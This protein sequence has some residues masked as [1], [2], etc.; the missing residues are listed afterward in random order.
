[1]TALMRAQ[2]TQLR[3]LRSTYVVAIAVVL[4]A[5]GIT[6][7]DLADA[8]GAK[9]DSP[10]ELRDALILDVGIVSALFAAM[11]ATLGTASEYRHQTIG[12]R[13]LGAP[14]RLSMLVARLF[15][16]GGLSAVAG[17]A[18]LGVSYALAGPVLDA[19]GLSLGLSSSEL[20]GIA[21]EVGLASVLFSMIG[22]AVGFICRSPA[23]AA[24]VVGGWFIVEKSL[25][26][27]LG[28][29][30]DYLPYALL[31]SVL[32]V[33]GAMAPAAA[34]IAL[35]GVTAVMA[36]ASGALLLRRDVG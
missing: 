17:L 12:L 7:A 3:T 26:D 10:G 35:C 13:V 33:E 9:L 4:V 5:A 2:L 22:V 20:A 16:Y 8:G 32:D 28:G 23:A 27:L 24:M 29:A 25:A 15:T 19:K 31:N 1:M 21:A 18:A 36:T 6:W 11:F 14:R 30:H 34:G